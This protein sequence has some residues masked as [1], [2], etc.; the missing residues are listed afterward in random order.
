MTRMTTILKL[1]PTN[2]G[3]YVDNRD[4]KMLMRLKLKHF[5]LNSLLFIIARSVAVL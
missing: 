3:S 1:I 2:T 4:E 5:L